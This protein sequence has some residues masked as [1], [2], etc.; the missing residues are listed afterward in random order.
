EQYFGE[1][2]AST[3]YVQNWH[4]ADNAVDYLAANN[5]PSAV[6]HFWTLSAEE[7]F[8]AMWPLVIGA[9][10][11]VASGRSARFKRHAI[12]TALGVIVIASLIYS[13]YESSRN[14][15]A[16]YFITTTRV[17]EFG[18]G[19]VVAFLW[20]EPSTARPP[21]RLALTWAGLA[22]IGVTSLLYSPATPFPG[23]LAAV[24]VI[25]A[26]MVIVAGPL[27]HLLAPTNAMRLRSVQFV[28]DISYS[29]Y[30]WHFPLIVI[31]PF[32]LGIPGGLP[33]QAVRLGILGAAFVL[34]AA[35]KI[36]VEDPIRFS[37]RLLGKRS[38]VTVLAYSLTA[39][40]VIV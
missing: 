8:Y 19:A 17:W 27:D 40:A 16:A 11:L 30:P 5:E 37:P 32:V 31:T 28:G 1:I 14:P 15:A 26:L 2:R 23:Y 12:L 35:S 9:G 10:L 7:Q 20:P 38:P 21:V 29:L 25:G 39:M 3:L 18:L 24:P 33:G 6:Q 4:L 34:A 36:W 13:V 22:M